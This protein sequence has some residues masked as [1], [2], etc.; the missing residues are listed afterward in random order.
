[1]LDLAF[2]AKDNLMDLG[3]FNEVDVLIDT[4]SGKVWLQMC[5]L[6][7]CIVTLW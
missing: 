3:I 2:E 7:L 5:I 6:S 1:M 4:S